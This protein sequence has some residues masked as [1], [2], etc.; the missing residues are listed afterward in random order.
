MLHPATTC[1]ADTA[2]AD[3]LPAVPAAALA[4]FWTGTST[5]APD[6]FCA[7][8]AELIVPFRLPIAFRPLSLTNPRMSIVPLK[9]LPSGDVPLTGT[10]E[11]GF[12]FDDCAR[13]AGT[14]AT[15]RARGRAARFRNATMCEPP[16]AP[17]GRT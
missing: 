10:A 4:T 15:A 5:T 7:P 9:V 12:R 11:N 3:G 6:T 1:C 14:S 13:A 2:L 17:M 16:E 8:R